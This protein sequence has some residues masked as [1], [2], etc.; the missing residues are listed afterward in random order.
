MCLLTG[1]GFARLG[2]AVEGASVIAANIIGLATVFVIGRAQQKKERDDKAN[3]QAGQPP[4]TQPK[5]KS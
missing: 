2:H 1:Y 3:I 5:L 4:K